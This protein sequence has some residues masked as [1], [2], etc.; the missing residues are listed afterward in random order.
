M[1]LVAGLIALAPIQCPSKEDP[2]LSR[3]ENPGDALY[4]LA[5][6]FRS[7]GNDAAYRETLRFLVARYPSNRRAV[8]AKMELDGSGSADAG[9]D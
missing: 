8:A 5:Q 9:G 6:D 1:L 4:E 7:K 3:S 2:A